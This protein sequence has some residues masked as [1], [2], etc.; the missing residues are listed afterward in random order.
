MPLPA[1]GQ[2]GLRNKQTIINFMRNVE[3]ADDSSDYDTIHSYYGIIDDDNDHFRANT[4]DEKKYRDII[5]LFVLDRYSKENYV[6]DPINIY[7]YLSKLLTDDERKKT[8]HKNID[9]LLKN[10]ETK[11]EKKFSSEMKRK[12][13]SFNLKDIYQQIQK[14]IKSVETVE[15]IEKFLQIIVD[16]VSEKVFDILFKKEE[17]FWKLSFSN[18]Y[19]LTTS[20]IVKWFLNLDSNLKEMIIQKSDS[21]DSFI[22]KGYKDTKYIC[23]NSQE[24]MKCFLKKL[25]E[26]HEFKFLDE[27]QKIIKALKTNKD[28]QLCSLLEKVTELKKIKLSDEHLQNIKKLD[29]LQPTELYN[30]FKD[31][32]KEKTTVRVLGIELN[33]PKFFTCLRGHCLE[34]VLKRDEMH[35]KNISCDKIIEKFKQT[36]TGIFIPD[37]IINIYRTICHNIIHD[38]NVF[39]L[40]KKKYKNRFILNWFI[41]MTD[42]C[43][44]FKR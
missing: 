22:K 38:K 21:N 13:L 36:D 41:L 7:F 17:T 14:P 23:I 5:N 4:P 27:D 2:T 35:L 15:C 25:T 37:V 29:K 10:I 12:L 32:C 28:S 20:I 19:S 18:K 30:F 43:K 40:V 26:L 34:G 11:V 9:G 8:C 39:E 44:E 31:L 24:V 42:D 1:G 6:L 3:P 33:Y 16:S